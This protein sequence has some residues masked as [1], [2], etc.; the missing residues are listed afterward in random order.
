M[1]RSRGY[2]NILSLGDIREKTSDGVSNR[3]IYYKPAIRELAI[4]IARQIACLIPVR[5][6]VR[7][8]L[9]NNI[10]Q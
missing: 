1:N 4:A 5:V 10:S 6:R 7:Y 8:V 9:R 3:T 2:Q